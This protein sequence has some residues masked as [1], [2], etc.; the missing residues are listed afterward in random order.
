MIKNV[1]F[2]LKKF[3]DFYDQHD[4][5]D[6]LKMISPYDTFL[7]PLTTFSIIYSLYS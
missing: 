1:G 4:F 7:K 5:G 2:H 3:D 6:L